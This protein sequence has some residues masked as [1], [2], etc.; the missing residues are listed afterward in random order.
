M[1]WKRTELNMGPSFSTIETWN[2]VCIL[3]LF[4]SKKRYKMWNDKEFIICDSLMCMSMSHRQSNQ[5]FLS[6]RLNGFILYMYNL[7]FSL[8][9]ADGH[10]S[11]WSFSSYSCSRNEFFTGFSAVFSLSNNVHLRHYLDLSLKKKT[12][13]RY[14]THNK[15]AKKKVNK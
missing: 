2:N 7:F 15:K 5:F 11:V 6:M 8:L 1:K 3:F 4:I 14:G 12:Q 13:G 9:F 10:C